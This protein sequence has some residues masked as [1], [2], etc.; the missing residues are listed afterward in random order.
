MNNIIIVDK[1]I[2]NQ[3]YFVKN[4]ENKIFLIFLTEEINQQGDLKIS[5][6]GKNANVQI[7]GIIIGSGDQ[8]IKLY[9]FQDHQEKE[10]TSDLFIKSILFDKSR[11]H[12]EGII[13][14]E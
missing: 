10:S 13:K 12:Y 11:F 6:K 1:L 4:G 14:I 2:K 9:T 3:E 5:I 8:Q 7:L